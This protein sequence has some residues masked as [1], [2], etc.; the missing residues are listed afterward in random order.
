M[1]DPTRRAWVQQIMGLPVSIH[2]RGTAPM[3]QREHAVAAVFAELR[4]VDRVFSTYRSDSEISRLRTG[5]LPVDECTSDV[6][7]VLDL[8]A[9]AG[10]ATG[11]YFSAWLPGPDG[12]APPPEDPNSLHREGRGRPTMAPP[13]E[14]PNSLHREGRG[15][16][17]MAQFDPTGLVKGWAVQRAAAHLAELTDDDYYVSAGGDI[18]LIVRADRPPWRVAVEDPR[19][20]SQRIAVLEV[21]GGGV[22]TSGTAHRGAHIIDPVR[23]GAATALASVTV[24]GP[25]LMW[26]DVFATAACARG[27]DALS[28]LDLPGGY[29]A[30]AVTADGELFH[31]AGLPALLA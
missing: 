10:R 3:S 31:T 15:R 16:P 13:P 28:Y 17:T 27:V 1:T 2:L 30:L 20:P 12:E 7:E 18:A 23:G 21:S 29:Q 19:Q 8:C 26:A 11:G 6:A 22:A 4:E 14:D 5:A 24:V 9:E 25:S